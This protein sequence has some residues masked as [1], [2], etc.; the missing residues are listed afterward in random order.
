MNKSCYAFIAVSASFLFLF[1]SSNSGLA[2]S[3]AQRCEKEKGD[4]AISACSEVIKS[5][6]KATYAYLRRGYEYFSRGSIEEPINDFNEAIKLDP[7]NPIAYHLRGMSLMNLILEENSIERAIADFSEAIRLKP[8]LADAYHERESAWQ[9]LEKLDRAIADLNQ[10]IRL[11]PSLA[12]AYN[13][14]GDIFLQQKRYEEALIDFNAGLRI[15]PNS[16][17]SFYAFMGRG[18]I[19]E[20]KGDL[21]SA[22]LSYQEYGKRAPNNLRVHDAIKRVQEKLS[23]LQN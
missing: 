18:E 8:D 9:M 21:H 19:L 3:D 7:S 16:L 20:R 23:K 1:F 2:Q 22:L 15:N 13:R 10:A 17:L 12:D 11:N 5:N 14:R 4:I 6:P